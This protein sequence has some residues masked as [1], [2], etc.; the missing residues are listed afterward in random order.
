MSKP[1]NPNSGVRCR[2]LG[3]H[4]R[5]AIIQDTTGPLDIQANKLARRFGLPSATA[6][7][8]AA[9]FYNAGGAA[10]V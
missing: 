1:K 7:T 2:V 4:R 5:Q 10:H 3:I 6:R 8:I 9:L